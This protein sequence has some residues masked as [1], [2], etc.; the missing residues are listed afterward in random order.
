VSVVVA[1][2]VPESCAAATVAGGG[3]TAVFSGGAVGAGIVALLEESAIA[4]AE[5]AA[6]S[7]DFSLRCF[8]KK[9]P[10]TATTT[11]RTPKI[12]TSSPALGPAGR[13]S[14]CAP[15]HDEFVCTPVGGTPGALK[16][17]DPVDAPGYGCC[18]IP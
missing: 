13:G 7:A 8:M 1:W 17:P 10:P 4:D 3:G 5:A 16:T 9:N 18:C 11:A 2:T 6:A 15:V 12:P 14:A